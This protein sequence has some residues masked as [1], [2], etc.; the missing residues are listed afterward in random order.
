ME[1]DFEK[2]VHLDFPLVPG[3]VLMPGEDK[4]EIPIT[5]TPR[6]LR[7]YQESIRLNF[8]NGLYFIEVSV[9]GQGIPLNLEMR[10]PDQSYTNLGIVSVG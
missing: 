6:E 2:K 5:F 3:Q 9:Q 8:N 7:K 1:S 10:D 4:V